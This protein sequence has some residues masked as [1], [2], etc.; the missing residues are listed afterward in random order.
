[1]FSNKNYKRDIDYVFKLSRFVFRLLGIW[2][3]A[4]TKSW[5]PET[6]ENVA[7]ILISYILLICELVPAILY[8][9]IVQRET[10]ARLKVVATV[11]F[12]ML[13]MAKYGQLLIKRNQMRNCLAQVEDDWQIVN[14]HDRNVMIDK[15][16]TSRRLL[17]IC[18]IFMYSTGVSFRTIIPLSAGKIVTKQN[19]TIRHLPCPTYFVLFDVQLSPA[20]EIVFLMQFF[21]GF[22][23]CTVTTAVCGLA[24]L[25]VMH[26]CAQLDILMVLMNNL[27]NERELK[28]MNERLTTIVK[29]QI[30]IRN[31]LQLVQN[32]IQY[33]SLMEIMGCT[34]IVCL[35]GYF[36]IMEWEDNNAVA[37]CSYLVGLTSI[38][39]NI[40][41]FCFIG[42]QLSAKG[43]KVALTACTMEWYRL[44]DA[45]ARSLILI[46][47]MSNSP[48]KVKGGKYFDLSFKTFGNVVKTAVTYL[49]LLRSVIG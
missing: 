12:T 48:T 38:S 47:L 11:I 7:V 5:L 27:I 14:L 44:P 4:R 30:K 34:I 49:N 23:K 43:E 40:F 32:T 36:V 3:Y 20:Y 22:V 6:L 41:I 24:G 45:K 2:P 18:A 33:T 39:F 13:A 19:F 35:L 25:F 15:A 31:F 28:N 29:H 8:M 21:S 42:E 9:A 1:M 10:R 46:M 37:L 16:R 26:I 17:I